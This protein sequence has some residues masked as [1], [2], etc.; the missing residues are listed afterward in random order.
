MGIFEFFWLM[1]LALYLI[2][3]AAGIYIVKTI[4][5]FVTG[6]ML[7]F[8]ASKMLSEKDR[9]WERPVSVTKPE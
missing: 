3:I 9:Q 4:A 5:G 7:G 2:P 6:G 8:K 1:K